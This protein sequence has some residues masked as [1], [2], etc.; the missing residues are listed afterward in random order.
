MIRITAQQQ[1]EFFNS[2]SPKEFMSF[3]LDM[4]KRGH[5][6][7]ICWYVKIYLAEKTGQSLTPKQIAIK[8][9]CKN[10]YANIDWSPYQQIIDKGEIG[11]QIQTEEELKLVLKDSF[12]GIMDGVKKVHNQN[13]GK[14]YSAFLELL[15]AHVDNLNF[16]KE[17]KP[18]RKL[19]SY[20]S[21][22]TKELLDLIET[23]KG[24]IYPLD[25]ITIKLTPECLMHIALG[26]IESYKIPRK[27]KMVQF[28]YIENWK[29]LAALIEYVIWLLKEDLN[30][31][32][33]KSLQDYNNTNIQILTQTYGI[34][35]NKKGCIKT[36]Y[37]I[38]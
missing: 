14:D 11:N 24:C 6:F 22:K 18:H 2:L 17:D 8:E 34:H 28:T 36:F 38:G 31:H 16:I 32:Y 29:V 33:N 4:E 37:E 3:C 7:S 27:G 13:N 35:I 26:H 15:E 30:A 12:L 25:K 1:L 9:K 21:Q 23:F 10:A 19:K 20:N 5:H